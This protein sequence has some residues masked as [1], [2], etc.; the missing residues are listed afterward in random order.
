MTLP[1]QPR[2][3]LYR[4]D[5]SPFSQKIDKILLLKKIPYQFVNVSSTLPRPEIKELLGIDYRRIPILAIDNDVYCDTSLIVSVLE[6]RFPPSSGYGTIFPSGK[7]GRGADTGAIKAFAQFY[8]DSTLFSPA[9]ALLPWDKLPEAILKDRSA[10]TGTPINLQAMKAMRGELLSRMSSHLSLME[11]QLSD[12]REWLF[13]TELPGLADISVH[14]ILEWARGLT[15]RDSLF[16]PTQSPNLIKWIDRL[17]AHIKDLKKL[18]AP[19]IQLKGNEAAQRILASPHEDRATVGFDL[20]EGSRLGLSVGDAVQ[21]A[22]TDTGR[23]YPTLGKLVGLNREESVI[24]I[25][26]TAGIVYCHFPR[27]GF[28]IKR[29]KTVQNKL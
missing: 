16:N 28:S 17:S 5:V 27:L 26:T 20:T 8:A 2:L 14:F 11:E 4:Y 25:P 15:Q 29:A 7:H 9:A 13:D 23:N 21:I 3:I 1:S 6:R 12:G 19:A 10:F 24:E 18:Q 22:P